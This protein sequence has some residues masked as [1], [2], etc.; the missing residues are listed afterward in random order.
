MNRFPTGRTF[1][2]YINPGDRKV[3]PDAEAVHGISNAMLVD[4][5]VFADIADEFLEFFAD[6][7]LVAHNASFDMS[8]V[9]TELRIIGRKPFDNDR[10][11][12]TLMIARR[13]HPAGPN[14]LDA[15][16]NRYGISNAHRTLHGALLDTE[17]LAEVYLELTGGRQAGLGLDDE[18][19][20]QGGNQVRTNVNTSPQRQ[21]PEP[22]PARLSEAE[23]LVHVE[24]EASLGEA[25]I[26]KKWR[27]SDE[28]DTNQS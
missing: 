6:G 27:Q 13:K 1:H 12:D 15:L 10:V 19:E 28:H 9:N 20:Q 25:S 4:K 2:K 17:L 18:V 11:I 14:S 22:L 23:R 26:W 3:H 8:F 24:F 7:S 5:P 21:R 16:C